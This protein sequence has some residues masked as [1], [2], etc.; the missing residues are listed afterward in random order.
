M[1]QR[2]YAVVTVLVVIGASAI[3]ITNVEVALLLGAFGALC[4]A[5]TLMERRQRCARQQQPE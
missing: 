3:A 2:H 5:G 4:L 1:R